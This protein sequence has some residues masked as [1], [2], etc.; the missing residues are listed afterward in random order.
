[1]PLRPSGFDPSE[2]LPLLVTWF[3]TGAPLQRWIQ[4]GEMAK[5]LPSAAVQELN[6]DPSPR[7]EDLPRNLEV[8]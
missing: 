1:V 4:P 2:T 3:G 8:V 6:E 5:L 7:L